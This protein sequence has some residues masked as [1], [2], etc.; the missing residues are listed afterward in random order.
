MG[1]FSGLEIKLMGA[2]VA[3]VLIVGVASYLEH[4]G[5]EKCVADNETHVAQQTAHKATVEAVDAVLVTQQKKAYDEAVDRPLV[6]PIAISLC[7]TAPSVVPA[8]T[9]ARPKSDAAPAS[10][11]VHRESVV[12]SATLGPGLQRTG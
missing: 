9:A 10:A 7:S 4:R 11:T 3:I 2:I 12:P 1:A 8:T 5:A 6:R